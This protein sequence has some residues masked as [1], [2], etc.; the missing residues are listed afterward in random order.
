MLLTCRPLHRLSPTHPLPH[1]QTM[2]VADLLRLAFANLRRN[3]MRSALTLVG[4]LI[5]VAALLALLAYGSGVQQ[6][7]RGEFN[8]LELYNTL[9][10]TARPN[11]IGSPGDLAF[12]TEAPA[13]TTPAV[14]LTDSLI[15]EIEQIEGVLAAYPEVGFPAQLSANG[16]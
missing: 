14:P 2:R 5:G 3:G 1:S 10:V 4:V 8:A 15:Q 12:R 6:A 16:R 13:D 11:P 9:R 7:A